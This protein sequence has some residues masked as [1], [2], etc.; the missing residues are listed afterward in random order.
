[1]IRINLLPSDKKKRVR[2]IAPSPLPGGDLSLGT[3][4]AVYGADLPDACSDGWR[5]PRP[6]LVLASELV[7][8]DHRDLHARGVGVR[9]QLRHD[10]R[11][12]GD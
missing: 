7:R 9:G 12:R 3:W 1:M 11:V 8:A 4:A 6:K 5:I 10:A 2:R